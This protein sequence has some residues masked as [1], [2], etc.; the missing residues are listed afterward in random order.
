MPSGALGDRLSRLPGVAECTVGDESVRLVATPGTDLRLLRARA[1]AVCADVGDRRALTVVVAPTS[2]L[3]P[4]VV[5]PQ[6]AFLTRLGGSRA[7]VLGSV[8]ALALIASLPGKHGGQPPPMASPGGLAVP[9]AGQSPRAG[10]ALALALRLPREDRRG[11][12]PTAAASVPEAVSGLTVALARLPAV[13]QLPPAERDEG[14]RPRAATPVDPPPAEPAA[15]AAPEP[16]PP[17]V[18]A[19]VAPAH[20][21]ITSTTT[22]KEKLTAKGKA[23]TM[24]TAPASTVSP[25]TAAAATTLTAEAAATTRVVSTEIDHTENG[26]KGSENPGSKG[27]NGKGSARP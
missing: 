1:H 10:S 15:T 22:G 24:A 7:V 11:R 25:T 21:P 16:E 27:G 14:A 6:S 13:V 4:Y 19:T 5:R 3:G 12:G 26:K 18:V 9:A 20:T 8:V 2:G 23:K 17:V